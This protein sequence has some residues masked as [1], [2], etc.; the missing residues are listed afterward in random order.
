MGLG[1]FLSFLLS[2]GGLQD[3]LW[4]VFWG[5]GLPDAGCCLVV[6]AL[7]WIF[8]FLEQFCAVGFVV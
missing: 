4:F 1:L 8:W 7:V 3:F 6:D 2:L 5:G